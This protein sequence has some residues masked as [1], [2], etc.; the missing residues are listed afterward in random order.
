MLIKIVD[1]SGLRQL[2]DA[3]AGAGVL[4]RGRVGS[5]PDVGVS[6]TGVGVS[7]TGVGGSKIFLHDLHAFQ[8]KNNTWNLNFFSRTQV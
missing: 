5:K 7:K 8:Y 1:I 2:L 4:K 3:G 6:K